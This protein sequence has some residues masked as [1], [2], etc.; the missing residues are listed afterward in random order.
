M[1][2]QD[3]TV[4]MGETMLGRKRLSVLGLLAV[5]ALVGA[6]CG[7]DDSGDGG[8]DETTTSAADSSETTAAEGD[9]FPTIEG[10][11]GVSDDEIAFSVVGIK[12]GNPLGTCILDCYVDGI[13]AFFDYQN[14]QGGVFGR[15]L[16]IGEVLDDELA[17]NQ[18]RSV[19]IIANDNSFGVFQ[20]TLI[21]SG[22]GDLDDAGIPTFVW[23][24][25]AAESA[26]REAIFGNVASLCIDCLGRAL[27]YEAQ[28]IGATKVA[29]LGYGISENSKVCAQ[30]SY[31]AFEKYGPEIGAE[32]AYLNDQMEF[33]LPGGVAT[34]VSAMI[35]AEVDFVTSCMD[36]NAMKTL[37]QEFDRQG[38]IDKVTLHHPNSYNHGF[39]A[40]NAALFEGDFVSPG[41][42]PYEADGEGTDLALVLERFEASGI[43][44]TEHAMVGWIN[45][46]E[47]FDAISGAGEE[48]DQQSAIDALN[49]ETS[50]SA[51]GLIPSIDWTTQHEPQSADGGGG[52]AL[53]CSAAVIIV[54]GVFETFASPETP[55]NCWD[56]SNR[57]WTEPEQIATP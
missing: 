55:W 11:P 46:R 43:E 49:S 41:F 34:E 42:I 30:S 39:V 15:D 45:A 19:E 25:H 10:V 48:F 44:L 57:D 24:I 17:N 5:F 16:V 2:V 47:A 54:D 28:S 18:A 3:L 27:P 7:D 36:L 6:A 56:N 21:A 8:G 20:A 22:W 35:D 33:G 53:E 37:A 32:A 29:A 26:G 14:E 12:E 9:A 13:Q 52:P 51:G 50:Y 23:N 4:M 38:Y 1:S 31:K 40:E